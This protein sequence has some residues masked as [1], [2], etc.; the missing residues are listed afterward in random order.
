MSWG[1]Q[2]VKT[3]LATA[4]PVDKKDPQPEKKASPSPFKIWTLASLRVAT[5]KPPEAIVEDLIAE[6]ET[7]AFVG[8]PKAGKSRFVQQ[9][10][11]AIASGQGFLGH[12]VPRTRRVLY[13]DLENRPAGVRARFQKMSQPS[14]A[15]DRLLIYAPETLS[16]LEITLATSAGIKA[17]QQLVSEVKPDL[18]IIDTWRL[19]LGGDENKTE[20][21]VRG[22]R[23]LSSLR[24]LVPALAT[25]IVHHTRKTQGQ[26]AP[27]LRIDPSGWVENASGHSSLVG[28][29]D[30]C[31]GL[32]REIDRNT[33][34]ELIVF[35]GVARSA[36]PRTLL[37]DEDTDALTFRIADGEDVVQK[38]LTP[39]E[40]AAW[41]SV[42]NLTEFTFGDVVEKARTKNRKLVVSL[43]RKLTSMNLIDRGLDRSLPQNSHTTELTELIN[44]IKNLRRNSERNWH[45]TEDRH[46]IT[47]AAGA[48]PVSSASVPLG[49]PV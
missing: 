19:L 3:L 15:D 28:H 39:K 27:V 1:H 8:K 33:G 12:V 30:G 31:F 47:S 34:D 18:L 25:L 17:L 16:N 49:V 7:I 44:E 2:E 32:E 40:R 9:I 46:G 24:R 45:G 13:L 26:D 21:V 29:T 38:L 36:A 5:F 20:V 42:E 11:L 43:L 22:L 35:G 41:L 23:A 10:A 6:G 14:A 37:L 4:K 48:V